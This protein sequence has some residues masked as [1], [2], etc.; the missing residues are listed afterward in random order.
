MFRPAT[1][2]PR[3]VSRS[4]ALRSASTNCSAMLVEPPSG[5]SGGIPNP[6]SLPQS[7]NGHQ[8][9]SVE[10]PIGPL[11]AQK[12][13][14]RGARADELF[15]NE[16]WIIAVHPEVVNHADPEQRECRDRL[17]HRSRI[18]AQGDPIG[19]TGIVEGRDR[20]AREAIVASDGVGD[21]RLDA[22]V[23][24]VLHLLPVRRV[25]VGVMRVEPRGAPADLP[26]FFQIGLVGREFGF[27]F[28]RKCGEPTLQMAELQRFVGRRRHRSEDS[29]MCA[30]PAARRRDWFCRRE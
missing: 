17:K 1:G 21:E 3:A 10:Q 22:R 30:R 28:E 23:A 7:T 14:E 4:A 8:N 29:A 19:N 13:I 24:D 15:A 20:L 2:S 16:S 18:T 9:E 11:M 5:S 26:N 6:K 25:H 27:L 12:P